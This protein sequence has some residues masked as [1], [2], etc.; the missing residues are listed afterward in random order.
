MFSYFFTFLL[1]T[2]SPDSFAQNYNLLDDLN[3]ME[4]DAACQKDYKFLE[5]EYSAL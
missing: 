3:Q 2:F 5:I 4:A 1:I